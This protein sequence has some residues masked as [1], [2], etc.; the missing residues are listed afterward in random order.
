MD[1]KTLDL[2]DTVYRQA[3]SDEHV[4]NRIVEIM[5]ALGRTNQLQKLNE[6]DMEY[7]EAASQKME[8]ES[9]SGNCCEE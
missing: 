5:K 3:R 8:V 2:L 9:I 6:V 4:K 7:E 1:E